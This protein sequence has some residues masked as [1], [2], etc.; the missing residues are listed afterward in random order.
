MTKVHIIADEKL[1]GVQ[2]EFIEVDRPAKV[3]DRI[4]CTQED[5]LGEG[6]YEVCDIF[7][8]TNANG[9]YAG[10]R[11]KNGTQRFGK[12]R[13]LEPTDIVVING[14]RF[15]MV[16]RKAKEGEKIIVV[17]WDDDSHIYDDVSIGE[18]LTVNYLAPAGS[19]WDVMDREIAAIITKNEY[20]VLEPVASDDLVIAEEGDDKSVIELLANLARRVTSLEQQLRDMQRNVETFAEQTEANTKD[21]AYL[22]ERTR[23]TND[24]PAFTLTQIIE[25][26]GGARR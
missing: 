20:R 11:D 14:E 8:V 19:I 3:G 17:D 23:S 18:T 16:D 2:R 15:R 24:G 10:F 12:F 1:G 25:A 6:G 5:P 22:D 13:T 21:I 4:I 26:L 9:G 7:V